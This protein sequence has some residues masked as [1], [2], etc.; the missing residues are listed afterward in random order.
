MGTIVR[1]VRRRPD[2][3]DP[4]QQAVG[5]AELLGD[6]GGAKPT[7]DGAMAA[8]EDDPAQQGREAGLAPAVQASGREHEPGGRFRRRHP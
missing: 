1:A 8:G 2:P 5:R 6:A 3:Y 4:P 7:G